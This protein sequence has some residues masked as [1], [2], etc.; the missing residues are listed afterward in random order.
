MGPPRVAPRQP[1]SVSKNFG[2]CSSRCVAART[3]S[4]SWLIRLV[5]AGYWTRMSRANV[6][7]SVSVSTMSCTVSRSPEIP[8]MLGELITDSCAQPEQRA[9]RSSH[10]SRSAATTAIA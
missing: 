8:S 10:V 3:F 4:A 5:C 2:F 9:S 1:M 7:R 6:P